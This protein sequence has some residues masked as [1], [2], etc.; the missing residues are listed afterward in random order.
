MRRLRSIP[1]WLR[2]LTQE[3]LSEIAQALNISWEA[4]LDSDL[5]QWSDDTPTDGGFLLSNAQIYDLLRTKSTEW[6]YINK[7]WK[8]LDSESHW[9]IRWKKFW[10]TDL[11]RRSKHFLWQICVGGLFTQERALKLGRGDGFCKSCPGIIE[12]PDHI[13][14]HCQQAQRGWASNALYYEADPSNNSLIHTNSFID[15]LDEAL[16]KSPQGTTRIYVIHQT[17]WALW[18]HRNG[19]LYNNQHCRFAPSVYAERAKESLEASI[20]YCTA[21]KKKTRMRKALALIV[22]YHTPTPAN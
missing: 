7:K 14:Y 9:T 11:S 15:I 18:K 12:D 3:F 22:P 1:Q 10:G 4:Q 8:R 6:E 13:F 20:R 21:T 2:D 19:R 17:C 16:D 5:W